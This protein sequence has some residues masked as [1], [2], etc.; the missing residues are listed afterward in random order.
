VVKAQGRN[1]GVM[2][3]GARHAAALQE[4]PESVPVPG[5]LRR[6]HQ[7]GGFEPGRQLVQRQGRGGGRVVDARVCDDGVVPMEAGPWV[8]PTPAH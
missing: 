6:E 3:L 2:H 5:G 7:V 4:V 8:A 1:P